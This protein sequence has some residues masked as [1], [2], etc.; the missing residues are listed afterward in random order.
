MQETINKDIPEP[1]KLIAVTQDELNDILEI[2]AMFLRGQVGGKRAMLQYKNLSDLNF[3]NHDLSQADF[4]GSI[5][6][7]ADLSLGTY[8]CACFFACNLEDADLSYSDM[9]RTDLRGAYLS[10]ANLSGTDFT[11]A[12]MR[13]GKVMQ[14]GKDGGLVNRK[15]SGGEGTKTILTGAHL[16]NANLSGVKASSADFTDANLSKV[17]THNANLKGATLK[18]ANLS[19]ADFTG[20]NITNV[21]MRDAII[22]GIILEGTEKF[23]LDTTNCITDDDIGKKIKDTY[24]TLEQLLYDHDI[25]LNTKGKKGSRLNLDGYDLRDITDLRMYKLTAIHAVN[26]YFLNLDLN[27]ISMQSAILDGSDFRDCYMENADLRGSSLKNVTM[28]RANLRGAQL[29]PLQFKT[30]G[31]IPKLNRID[32]SGA[33]LRFTN[34]QQAD[35]RDSIMMGVDLTNADLSGADLRRADLSGAIIKNTC[36]DDAKLDGAIIN[37]KDI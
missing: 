33:D 5:L 13:E 12:D 17:T 8:K 19:N 36:L 35:M 15:R 31:K 29:S 6:S 24:Q 16:S 34:L 7:R 18:G 30:K 20:A 21:N 26:A 2:H 1:E 9:S 10:G 25:W 28:V 3:H 37:F 4:T 27:R 11:D 22:S 23:G 32:L 14:K